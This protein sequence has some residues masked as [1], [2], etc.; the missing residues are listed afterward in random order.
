MRNLNGSVD[1]V[2]IFNRALG[3]GEVE[4][5]FVKGRALFD[6]SDYQSSDA[7]VINE[8]STNFI[9]DYLL[10][11][12]DSTHPDYS[13]VLDV[14]SVTVQSGYLLGDANLDWIVDEGDA[15][16]VAAHWRTLLGAT[17]M[18]GDFND[19]GRV[20]DRDASILASHWGESMETRAPEVSPNTSEL[21]ISVTPNTPTPELATSVTPEVPEPDVS[22]TPDSEPAIRKAT[23]FIGPLPVS[24]LSAARRRLEPCRSTN[25][26]DALTIEQAA[27]LAATAHDAVLAD[28]IDAAE[29][30]EYRLA[31]MS[32]STQLRHRR[33]LVKP[34]VTSAAALTL[35]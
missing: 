15:R 9:V 12:G 33:L 17:W 24:A 19:D 22:E 25:R 28:P 20:D 29:L 31:W 16:I 3:E 5:L 11:A 4:E 32:E 10:S 2:M 35:L 34:D 23:P 6:Y 7:F 21:V 14:T 18:D 26:V 13:P 30:A 8:N 27:P 1:E